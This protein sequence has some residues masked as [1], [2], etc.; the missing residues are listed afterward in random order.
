MKKPI[1]LILL[2]YI[3]SAA[4]AGINKKSGEVQFLVSL[5][6][7]VS[8]MDEISQFLG[9]PTRTEKSEKKILF[10]YRSTE[11]TISV[12]GDAPSGKLVKV[13]YTALPYSDANWTGEKASALAGTEVSL[14]DILS[15]YG[16]PNAM[17]ISGRE[18]RL[19]YIYAAD[20]VTLNF[21]NGTLL[22][23]SVSHKAPQKK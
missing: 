2:L 5:Q 18:Q 8:T 12:Y 1:L 6:P 15:R 11:R 4:F 23:Y 7:L 22:Q 14:T 13:T 3:S 17:M 21:L 9:E 16:K 20:N 10:I 19:N